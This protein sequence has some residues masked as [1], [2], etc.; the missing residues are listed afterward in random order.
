MLSLTKHPRQRVEFGAPNFLTS[1]KLF[2]TC[3]NVVEMMWFCFQAGGPEQQ[4]QQQ[5]VG[6]M[7]QQPAANAGYSNMVSIWFI[8]LITILIHVSLSFALLLSC[9]NFVQTSNG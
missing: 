5:N 7:C 1:C 8:F 3:N 6:G 2:I 9:Y 4:M